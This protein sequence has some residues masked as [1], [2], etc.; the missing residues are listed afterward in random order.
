V[1]R[2]SKG[3]AHR[4]WSVSTALKLDPLPIYDEEWEDQDVLRLPLSAVWERI[5][6][7]V[8]DVLTELH[9]GV[10][11]ARWWK[12]VPKMDVEILLGVE[13]IIIIGRPYEPS[14]LPMGYAVRFAFA[15]PRREAGSLV[16]QENLHS[17]VL[18]MSPARYF[19]LNMC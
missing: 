3:K 11:E 13:A 9:E 4:R 10:Y 12:P 6:P 14:D 2:S 19:R 5:A 18:S 7:A 1:P 15:P 17:F 8:P 16:P